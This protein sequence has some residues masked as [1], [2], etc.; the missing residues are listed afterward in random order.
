MTLIGLDALAPAVEREECARC[1]IEGRC[2]RGVVF[3]FNAY[4]LTTRHCTCSCHVG[5]DPESPQ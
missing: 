5:G 1:D 3:T 2:A 4:G